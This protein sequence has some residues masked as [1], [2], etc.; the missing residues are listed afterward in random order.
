[1]KKPLILLT[2]CLPILISCSC[3][4]TNKDKDREEKEADIPTQINIKVDELTEDKYKSVPSYIVARL[5]EFTSY[6]AV[7]KGSTKATV[8]V[9]F[10][11]DTEQS[12]DVTMIKG[13]EYSYLK[14]ESHSSFVNTVH[15]A[16]FKGDQTYSKNN[17]GDYQLKPLSDYLKTYGTYP[18]DTAIEGYT[19]TDEDIKSVTKLESAENHKFKIEFNTETCTN[20]V[21]IQMREF[22]GLDDYPS[23]SKVEITVTL[24]ND[25]TPITY[26]LESIYT[27]KKGMDSECHQKYTVTFSDIN[28]NPEI[29]DLAKIKE[30]L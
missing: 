4:Q 1:M 30:K 14:N 25:W 16:Y 18:F 7:T 26:E 3:S 28:K 2:L 21:K 24:K 9:I 29:P 15:T 27:A 22:G 17:D 13:E 19:I 6:K 12:I 20:N 23:I 5:R 11:I 8:V 10:P